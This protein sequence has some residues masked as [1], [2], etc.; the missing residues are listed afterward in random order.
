MARKS[1]IP[2]TLSTLEVID[3]QKHVVDNGRVLGITKSGRC[4]DDSMLVSLVIEAMKRRY[5]EAVVR[6]RD[7]DRRSERPPSPA[8]ASNQRVPQCFVAGT[9]FIVLAGYRLTCALYWK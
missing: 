5:S 4:S 2:S 3:P 9:A 7:P 6:E 8:T 1:Q